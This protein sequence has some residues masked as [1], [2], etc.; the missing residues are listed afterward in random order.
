MK[1]TRLAWLILSFCLAAVLSAMGWIT[2]TLLDLD[3]QEAEARQAAAFEQHV[4]LALWRLDARVNLLLARAAAPSPEAVP[5]LVKSRYLYKG[6]QL[7]T[8]A[9]GQFAPGREVLLKRL[10]APSFDAAGIGEADNEQTVRNRLEWTARRQRARA[11]GWRTLWV[12]NQLVTVKKTG[13]MISGEVLDWPALRQ[14]LQREIES[15]LAGAALAPI[16][17]GETVRPGRRLASL[18]VK[19]EP[20]KVVFYYQRPASPIKL[21]LL[22]AWSCMLLPAAGV[23]ILLVAAISLNERRGAFVSAV[24]HELRTPLTTFRMYTE[25]LDEG[26][27]ASEKRQ[28]YLSTL[29]HEA[30]RLSHLVENVLTYARIERGKLQETIQTVPLAELL[31]RVGDELRRRTERDGMTLEAARPDAQVMVSV[32]TAGVERIL[33]NLIDNACK[34][35][36]GAE[37]KRIHLDVELGDDKV[38]LTVRDHGPGISRRDERKLFRPFSK[39]DREAAHSAAGVGL[40]LALSRRLA[41]RMDGELSLDHNHEPGAAFIL[42]LPLADRKAVSRS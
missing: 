27:V 40:G 26:M 37:D 32:D 16:K 30:E 10:A 21:M 4:R 38:R 28:E 41:R 24:T 18:P 6:K 42:R 8:L 5:P 29:R 1:R 25:M 23:A 36:A 15:L 39:S 22:I 31:D 13:A 7:A 12:D 9:A 2:V 20:G 14:E 11:S 17:P 35:A 34:Y 33:V 19:L 3:R